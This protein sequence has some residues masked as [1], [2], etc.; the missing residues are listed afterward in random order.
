MP[1]VPKERPLEVGLQEANDD[2]KRM[3]LK[4]R[5]EN[6]YGKLAL[7]AT[8]PAR[9]GGGGRKQQRVQTGLEATSR[10]LPTAFKKAERLGI[11][12]RRDTFSWEEWGS[13]PTESTPTELELTVEDFHRAAK[14]L[15]AAKYRRKPPENAEAIWGKKWRPALNKIPPSGAITE[16]VLLRVIR[17]MP[18]ESAARRDQGNLITQIAD[19]LGLPTEK[20]REA[21]RGYSAEELSPRQIPSDQEILEAF[22]SIR[23][24]RW[25]W[26]FGMCAAYGLRPHECAELAWQED[27]WI[28]VHD[29][30]KTGSRLVTPCPAEWVRK[31]DLHQL[32]RPT[33]GAKQIGKVFCDALDR[34]GIAIAPYDLRHAFALRLLSKGV[35]TETGARLM[36][37][38]PQVHHQ[39]Y[40][41]WIAEDQIKEDMKGIR[42]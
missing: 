16:D 10:F 31:L 11:Q 20:L 37:H 6:H 26:M 4:V 13:E 32:P 30:T 38:S 18:L 39:T 40:R 19:S 22:A 33:Q 27:D 36:G 5:M 8:L 29:Y 2:L 1:R 35:P 17:K 24:P 25:K 28:R 42:L 21:Y 15:H 14:Q 12:I 23:L 41:R 3:G 34:D 9:N 7:R